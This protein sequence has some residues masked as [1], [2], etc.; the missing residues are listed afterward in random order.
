MSNNEQLFA[1]I[2]PTEEA[3]LSGG[4]GFANIAAATA[5]VYVSGNDYNRA[6][7]LTN[8]Q[9]HTNQHAT[10]SSAISLGVGVGVD[11]HSPFI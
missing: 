5:N 3:N 9:V 7:T 6:H 11:I 10:I 4:M 2:I 1:E 8:A